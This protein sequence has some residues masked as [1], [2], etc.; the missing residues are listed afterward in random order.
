MA[1]LRRLLG[2][3]LLGS[4]PYRLRMPVHADFVELAQLLEKGAVAEAFRRYRGPVL[5]PPR[6]RASSSCAAGSSGR[7]GPAC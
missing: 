7:S 5:P 4:R 1:R 3:E 2:D 6:R